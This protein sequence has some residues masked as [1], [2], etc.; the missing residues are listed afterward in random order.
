M[1]AR[2]GRDADAGG[3]RPSHLVECRG[4]REMHDVH[5]RVGR[6]GEGERAGGRDGFDVRWSRDSVVARQRIT[7]LQRRRH[8][9]IEQHRILAVNLEHPAVRRH[10]AHRIEQRLIGQPEVE[11]HERLR[12]RDT[13]VDGGGQLRE[14]V[15]RVAGDRQGEAVV[16]GA[17]GVRRGLPFRQPR[18]ERPLGGRRRTRPGVV[19]REERGR[20]AVRRRDRV[21]EEP[22][23]LVI[24]R[25]AGVSVD[26]DGTGEYQ[27]PG[28]VDHTI[29]TGRR[30]G[31]VVLDRT[32]AAAFG[33]EISPA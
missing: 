12:G 7:T 6:P 30:P 11:H 4:R 28:R 32:D 17:V 1:G 33:R 15:V 26:V 14:R 21:L 31:Q 8:R 22:V 29:R 23:G 25:D 9:R 3:P 19:E 20:A 2:L 10:H 16:D 13:A 18:H 27:H 24:G 5:G